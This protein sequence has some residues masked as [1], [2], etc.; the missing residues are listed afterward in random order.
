MHLK[1]PD[2]VENKERFEIFLYKQTEDKFLH[3]I[4]NKSNDV[5]F[6]NKHWFIYQTANFFLVI[7]G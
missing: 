1:K 7:N 2:F 6:N 5:N 3:N 4:S